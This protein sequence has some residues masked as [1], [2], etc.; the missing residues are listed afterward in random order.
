MPSLSDKLN[1]LPDIRVVIRNTQ[2]KYLAQD[3][4]G[5]FFTEDRSAALVFNYRSDSV[6]EQIETIATT[7]GIALVAEPVPPEEIYE[8]CDRCK[9]LFM[10]FMILFDGKRF[11]CPDCRRRVSGRSARS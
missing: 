8:T 2:G 10:P 5:L 6:P 7:H 4:Y 3:A 1:G 11:L 9:D